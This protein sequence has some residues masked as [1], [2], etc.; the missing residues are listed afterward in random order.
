M[1]TGSLD[2]FL[3]LHLEMTPKIRMPDN[4]QIITAATI[5]YFPGVQLLYSS[6]LHTHENFTLIVFGMGLTQEQEDWCNAI[7]HIVLRRFFMKD[8][9]I[10]ASFYKPFLLSI[11]QK[12]QPL[13]IWIDCDCIVKA[14]LLPL[15]HHI[16]RQPFIVQNPCCTP[17]DREL[18]KH[19]PDDIDTREDFSVAAGVFAWNASRQLDRD[20]IDF[21][22]GISEIVMF[23]KPELMTYTRNWDESLLRVV[24]QKYRIYNLVWYDMNWN[25][26][27][28]ERFDSIIDALVNI[29]HRCPTHHILHYFGRPKIWEKS[30]AELLDIY[31]FGK[32]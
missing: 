21:W 6:L 11:A 22:V 15:L 16:E 1:Q 25:Q 3:K 4:S 2:Q 5:N 17:N 26:V 10:P 12:M 23:E 27:V 8:V 31:P 29:H 24:V 30:G 20:I 18:Y 9:S 32:R 14:S 28:Y 7:P 13:N 19:I